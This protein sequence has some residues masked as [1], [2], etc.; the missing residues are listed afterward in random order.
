MAIIKSGSLLIL[1]FDAEML[2]K[3]LNSFKVFGREVNKLSSILS[4]SN[5]RISAKRKTR[6]KI[7]F[8]ILCCE[9]RGV[10][11]DDASLKVKIFINYPWLCRWKTGKPKQPERKLKCIRNRLASKTVLL[12]ISREAF[13]FSSK[14]YAN[15]LFN[16]F[17][18]RW[19]VDRKT[20]SKWRI[21]NRKS[22]KLFNKVFVT[23]RLI[24]IK[25]QSMCDSSFHIVREW[26]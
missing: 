1:L 6:Q 4:S 17:V 20:S 5:L 3:F 2:F 26:K 15:L 9:V 14:I 12:S 19:S 24:T 8:G 13:K 25:R 21:R 23:F 7:Y 11:D 16:L 22:L 10:G 18:A